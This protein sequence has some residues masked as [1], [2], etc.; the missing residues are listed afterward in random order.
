MWVDQMQRHQLDVL[1]AHLCRTMKPRLP[2]LYVGCAHIAEFLL[3]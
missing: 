3:H 2:Q 1:S